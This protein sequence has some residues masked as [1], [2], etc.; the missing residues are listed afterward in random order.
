MRRWEWEGESERK[1][2]W[3][4]ENK[5]ERSWEWEELRMRMKMKW[6]ALLFLLIV[7]SI[8]LESDPQAIA[9]RVALKGIGDEEDDA[10]IAEQTVQQ[11]VNVGV[12]YAKYIWDAFTR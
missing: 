12:D 6:N 8:Y 9:N 3:E 7:I 2:G 11:V 10:V 1:R 4:G 5:N